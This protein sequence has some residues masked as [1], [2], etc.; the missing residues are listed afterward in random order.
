M[1]QP[2]LDRVLLPPIDDSNNSLTVQDL[3]DRI[4]G[5]NNFT[6]EQEIINGVDPNIANK[7]RLNTDIQQGLSVQ[8]L[9][10]NIFSNRNITETDDQSTVVQLQSTTSR[11]LVDDKISQPKDTNFNQK[12]LQ[13]STEEPLIVSTGSKNNQNEGSTIGPLVISSSIKEMKP[14][15]DI[16]FKNVNAGDNNQNISS[17]TEQ[18]SK[19]ETTIPILSNGLQIEQI[20]IPD[21]DYHHRTQKKFNNTQYYPNL[22]IN[23]QQLHNANSSEQTSNNNYFDEYHNIYWFIKQSWDRFKSNHGSVRKFF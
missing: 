3:I 2:A 1:L 8:D 10:D 17:M 20:P 11:N 21:T 6:E 5:P 18:S 22:N 13:S 14:N 15:I 9:I 23:K 4:F 16:R 19:V 12:P 7:N